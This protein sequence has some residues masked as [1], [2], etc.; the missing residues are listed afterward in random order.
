MQ[1]LRRG[2]TEKTERNLVRVT[3]ETKA[4]QRMH[5]PSVLPG[6]VEGV[7]CVPRHPLHLVLN[8]NQH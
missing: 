2:T 5:R 6:K 4:E 1:A 8:V 7:M 3:P